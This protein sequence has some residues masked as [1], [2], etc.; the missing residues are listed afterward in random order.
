[1][2]IGIGLGL[3]GFPFSSPKAFLSWIDLCEDQGV[4][5]VWLS[6]RI[7]S[8]QP[9]P[10]LMTTF[11]IIAGRTERLKFGMNAIVVSLRDPLILAKECASLDYLSGGRLLPVFGVGG[12]LN[13]EFRATSRSPKGR[14][15]QSDEALDIMAALWTGEP[16]TYAGKYYQY[17]EAV[18]SPRPAQDPLPLWIGGSSEAAIRR[19]ARIGTGW[20]GGIQAPAQVAPV[21]AAIRQQS[22]AAGRPIDDDHYGAGF[23]FRFGSWDEPVVQRQAAALARI[24]DAPPPA[25][26]V[27]VGDAGAIAERIREYIAAGVSKFVLRPIADSDDE[28]LAQTRRLT[29]EVIPLFASS[30]T[31]VSAAG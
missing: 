31:P 18:I 29:A 14:G 3:A 1:M 2:S 21:V 4:D 16:V 7:V 19:T 30:R 6:E 11:G 8:R 12:E 28:I 22:A 13:P 20:L 26:Y 17:T 27:A 25:D 24:P 10:E 23:A 15:P 9:T 5:S